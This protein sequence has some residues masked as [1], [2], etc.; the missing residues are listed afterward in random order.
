MQEPWLPSLVWEDLTCLRATKALRHI[1]GVGA[2]EPGSHKCWAH[3]PGDRLGGR[4]NCL[5]TSELAQGA[6]QCSTQSGTSGSHAPLHLLSPTSPGAEEFYDREWGRGANCL[7]LA[8]ASS[9]ALFAPLCQRPRGKGV[10]GSSENPFQRAPLADPLLS[11]AGGGIPGGRVRVPGAAAVCEIAQTAL[12]LGWCV[13]LQLDLR[14]RPRGQWERVQVPVLS[15]G[16]GRWHPEPARGHRW[17][18]GAWECKTPGAGEKL[19]GK[20]EGSVAFGVTEE[21]GCSSWHRAVEAGRG[22]RCWR[23]RGQPQG[24]AEGPLA[25]TG[26]RLSGGAL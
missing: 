7:V 6:A 3:G 13:V 10:Q 8:P 17:A 20:G 23:V 25:G 24:W 11:P 21:A 5:V 19:R 18:A 12:P 4:G 2:P 9:L 14:A 26:E 15:L 16:G 22:Q 1:Y